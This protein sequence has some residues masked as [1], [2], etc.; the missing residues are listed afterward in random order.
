MVQ[1]AP[2]GRDLCVHR[3]ELMRALSGS[4]VMQGSIRIMSRARI[5][6]LTIVIGLAAGGI[7]CYLLR[8]HTSRYT[9]KTYVEVLPP[10]EAEPLAGQSHQTQEDIEYARRY[11]IARIIRSSWTFEELVGREAIHRTKWFRSFGR[12]ADEAADGAIE[13]F[14]KHLWSSARRDGNLVE[15]RMT[16][17]SA[18]DAALIVNQVIDLMFERQDPNR[19]ESAIPIRLLQRER[20]R[21]QARLSAIESDNSDLSPAQAEQREGVRK[22]MARIVD[23]IDHK[24]EEIRQMRERS[25]IKLKRVGSG[26]VPVRVRYP[27]GPFWYV[28]AGGILGF[29]FGLIFVFLSDKAKY[30]REHSG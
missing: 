26:P 18:E 7:A 23:A 4:D 12:V 17:R 8:K 11:T 22:E 9:A 5:F 10:A 30:H 28:P 15:I 21:V 25:Q 13:D 3:Y 14:K 2:T 6:L 20:E 27:V 29:V 19:Q 24:I 16:C 1:P